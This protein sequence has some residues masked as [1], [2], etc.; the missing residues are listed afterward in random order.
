M[1]HL[2]TWS[3]AG[4]PKIATC[5]PVMLA[6]IERWLHYRG[7]LQCVVLVSAIWP[8]RMAVLERWLYSD[9][10]RELPLYSAVAVGLLDLSR[11]GEEGDWSVVVCSSESANVT[12]L[13]HVIDFVSVSYKIS[14]P[15]CWP[16]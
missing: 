7:R 15:P 6:F 11:R 12:H 3:S 5:G 2:V 4:E 14:R 1:E 13:F 8:G 9:H 10:Y 16:L